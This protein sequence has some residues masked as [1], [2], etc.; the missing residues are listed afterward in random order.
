MLQT[1]AVSLAAIATL[2]VLSEAPAEPS[3][4]RPRK[5]ATGGLVMYD[6][7]MKKKPGKALKAQ[8]KQQKLDKPTF[9]EKFMMGLKKFGSQ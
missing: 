7:A 9:G 1:L 8:P 2:A 4:N 5:T 3:K 6:S